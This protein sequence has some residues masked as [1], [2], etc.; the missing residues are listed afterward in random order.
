MISN[1]SDM[2][3]NSD[4]WSGCKTVKILSQFQTNEVIDLI[5]NI[6]TERQ[7]AIRVS[8]RQTVSDYDKSTNEA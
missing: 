5:R 2:V 6:R 7:K 1:A 4:V 8:S 3:P